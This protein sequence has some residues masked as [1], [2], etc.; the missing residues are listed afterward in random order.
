[1]S[2]R[3][4]ID[5]MGGDHAPL[6]VIKGVSLFLKDFHSHYP[7][8][9]LHFFGDQ[10]VL[11]PLVKAEKF[12]AHV[13]IIHCPTQ[14]QDDMKPLEVLRHSKE[15]SMRRAIEAVAEGHADVVISGGNTGGYLTLAKM[16]LK[17]LDG[18]DRPALAS[19]WPN[20][21][22]HSLV[23]DLGANLTCSAE[24][25]VEFAM[26]GDSYMR[27]IVG[28]HQPTIGILNV[29]TEETKG[30]EALRQAAATLKE[31]P[32]IHYHGFVEGYDIFR[33][34]TDI[35][36]CDGFLGNIALKTAEGAYGTFKNVLSQTFQ[37]SWLTRLSFLMARGRLKTTFGQIDPRNYN[38]A[39]FLGLR[40]PA[41]KSH[42][43]ADSFAYSRAIKIGA[44]MVA[45]K[46]LNNHIQA[47]IQGIYP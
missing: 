2:L 13:D 35:V 20:L 11:A 36:I 22:S 12:P 43:G 9:S 45:C 31:L 32:D 25:L 34:T 28:R 5:A 15:T 23:M 7:S 44:E 37:H 30:N 10:A 46:G 18:V 16:I 33:G 38:G 47:K 21:K 6:S 42:G 8:L 40:A 39:I 17:T 29:G 27:Y 4:A 1:M 41:I 3:I 14:V 19:L 26:M 24:N